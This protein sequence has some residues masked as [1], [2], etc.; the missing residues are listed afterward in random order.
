MNL[1][2]I[3]LILTVVPLILEIIA[4]LDSISAKSGDGVDKKEYIKQTL[5]VLGDNFE[6]IWP[7]LGLIVDLT[8]SL[9]NKIGVFDSE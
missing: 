8:V 2:N 5:D 7:V 9:F 3:K 6:G 1:A 4:K